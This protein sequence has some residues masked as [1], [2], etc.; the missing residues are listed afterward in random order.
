M[1]LKAKAETQIRYVRFLVLASQRW[2]W[3]LED[4][5]THW[6]RFPGRNE[7]LTV[8]YDRCSD[9]HIIIVAPPKSVALPL[10]LS[11][12]RPTTGA[13]LSKATS[14]NMTFCRKVNTDLS[15]N[16]LLTSLST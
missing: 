16:I 14:T 12:A 6:I 4:V 15:A 3:L 5:Q 11:V 7:D 1:P 9:S 8:L 10:L 13:K 2:H